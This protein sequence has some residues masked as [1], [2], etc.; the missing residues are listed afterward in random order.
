MPYPETAG[1]G[2]LLVSTLQSIGRLAHTW[3]GVFP[4]AIGGDWVVCCR[5]TCRSP[6]AMPNSIHVHRRRLGVQFLLVARVIPQ[7]KTEIRCRVTSRCQSCRRVGAAEPVSI[8]RGAYHSSQCR[9]VA[10]SP[11][12]ENPICEHERRVKLIRRMQG[13]ARIEKLSLQVPA[14]FLSSTCRHLLAPVASTFL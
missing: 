4:I 8:V 1:S 10:V 11:A 13:L 2:P 6:H 3:R 12:R 9:F 14:L 5:A 7:R